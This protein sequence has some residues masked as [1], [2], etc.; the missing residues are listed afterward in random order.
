MK[1]FTPDTLAF[2]AENHGTNSKEWFNEHKS[3]FQ[4]YV[5]EPL[6][7]MTEALAPTVKAIDEKMVTDAKVDKTISRIWCDMRYSRGLMFRDMMW[8]SFRRN[9]AEYPGWPE[10]F[11]IISPKSFFYGCGYYSASSAVMDKIRSLILAG[12][13]HWLRA[14]EAYRNQNTFRLGDER[15]KRARYPD[16][17]ED[18]REWLEQKSLCFLHYP[19]VDAMFED[20]LA[21][22]VAAD[23]MTM[24]PVHEFLVY[25]EECVMQ[26]QMH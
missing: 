1:Q 6:T 11:V 19:G 14:K 5:M 21:D 13:P 25:A 2:L 3:L 26:E 23:W 8:I 18:N 12:D 24:K 22:T 17:P 7:A 20:N 10:F 16:A 4:Q 15:Y 9:K